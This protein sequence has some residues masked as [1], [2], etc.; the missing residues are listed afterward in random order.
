MTTEGT[1]ENY[2]YRP[3][4]GAQG[5][6]EFTAFDTGLVSADSVLTCA[7]S[8]IDGSFAIINVNT[9]ITAVAVSATRGNITSVYATTI[10]GSDIR[11]STI[12]GGYIHSTTCTAVTIE[13][14]G[15]IGG[16]RFYDR[17]TGVGAILLYSPTANTIRLYNGLTDALVFDFTKQYVGNNHVITTRTLGF[18]AT[19]DGTA[20]SAAWIPITATTS[21]VHVS[22]L[23]TAMC[24]AGAAEMSAASYKVEG[25]IDKSGA[26]VL[27]T[28]TPFTATAQLSAYFPTIKGGTGYAALTVEGS[29]GHKVIWGY[30]LT[31][32]ILT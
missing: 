16:L 19:E 9:G 28:T 7:A 21:A 32:V 11:A 26:V 1:Q 22:A 20:A 3:P 15:T 6:E 13:V 18:C 10:T 4:Y 30:D 24:T 25:T 12:S 5:S 8:A 23:I 17:S 27:V 29:A 31:Y 2:L 14:G